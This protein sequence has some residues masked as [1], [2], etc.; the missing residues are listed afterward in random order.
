MEVR[1]FVSGVLQV[2][3]TAIIILA[4]LLIWFGN[5]SFWHSLLLF[6]SSY[7][8]CTITACRLLHH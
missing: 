7:L 3:I 6:T 1:C 5:S 8:E 2:V 4:E